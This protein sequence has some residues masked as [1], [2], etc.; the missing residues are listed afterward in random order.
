[1]EKLSNLITE[2]AADMEKAR[3]PR[4]AKSWLK[5]SSI[6]RAAMLTALALV[7]SYVE[8]LLP[9]SVG[10]PGIKPGFA[11][12]VIVFALYMLDGR[13]AVLVNI[14]RVLLSSLLFGTTFSALY[15]AAGAV[16]SLAAM[17]L[18]KKTNLFSV[19]AV[20]AA[21]GVFHNLGQ[22]LVAALVVKTPEAALYFPV[23]LFS[24]VA[25]GTIVGIISVLCMG[26]LRG[27]MHRRP[28]LSEESARRA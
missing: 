25:A 9:F 28:Q 5:A 14:C 3:K 2:T 4:P 23:L 7:F 18:L 6:A 11:N 10:I 20:S 24:G 27:T 21:G 8:L 19:T 13:Y 26:A 12:I 17:I 1:M 15:A 16:I 22:L